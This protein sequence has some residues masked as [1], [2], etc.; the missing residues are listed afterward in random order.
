MMNYSQQKLLDKDP[1]Q[2]LLNK[3]RAQHYSYMKQKNQGS[4]I[5]HGGGNQ[6]DSFGKIRQSFGKTTMGFNRNLN[7]TIDAASN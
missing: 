6:Y 3:G 5:S 7:K 1:K 4:V 2:Y